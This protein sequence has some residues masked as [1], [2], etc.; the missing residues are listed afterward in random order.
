MPGSAAACTTPSRGDSE[1]GTPAR[2]DLDNFSLQVPALS[3]FCP[4]LSGPF[5]TALW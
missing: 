1:D 4:H 5:G 2:G 3:P